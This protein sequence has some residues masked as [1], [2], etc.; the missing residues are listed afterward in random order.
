MAPNVHP[1]IAWRTATTA[2][3]RIGVKKIFVFVLAGTALIAN[4][5]F[6]GVMTQV[7]P[8]D[9]AIGRLLAAVGFVGR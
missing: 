7:A 5:H 2:S 9:D 6:H 1:G 8:I 4:L 3:G